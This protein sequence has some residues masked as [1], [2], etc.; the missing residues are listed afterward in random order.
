[1]H[2]PHGV[3]SDIRSSAL[4]GRGDDD[5]RRRHGIVGRVPRGRTT[6]LATLVLLLLPSVLAGAPIAT[7]GNPHTAYMTAALADATSSNP[8]AQFNVIVTGAHGQ[9][10]NAV[11]RAVAGPNA[12]GPGNPVKEQYS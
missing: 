3:R 5:G 6:L 11:A 10:A 12:D 1:M 2:K 7:A 9:S 4:W 8:S